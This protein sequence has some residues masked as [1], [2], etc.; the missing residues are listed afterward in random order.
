MTQYTLLYLD[1]GRHHHNR[2]H[3]ITA[4]AKLQKCRV[5][6]WAMRYPDGC[7]QLIRITRSLAT[8][9]QKLLQRHAPNTS[10]RDQLDFSV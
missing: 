2:D 10:Y 4:M 5:R 6:L 1:H 8:P 7:D 3:Q 9:Q